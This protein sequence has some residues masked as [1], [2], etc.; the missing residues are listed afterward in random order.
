MSRIREI[1]KKIDNL[2]AS[3]KFKLACKAAVR[4]SYKLCLTTEDA[5]DCLRGKLDIADCGT[6][7]TRKDCIKIAQEITLI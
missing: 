4:Q 3:H 2:V 5:V 6:G 1:D 7:L